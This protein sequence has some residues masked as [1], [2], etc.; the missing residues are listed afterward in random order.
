LP[1]TETDTTFHL[2]S[3]FLLE[4]FISEE[5]KMKQKLLIIT[6]LMLVLN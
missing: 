6:A 1:F 3:A 5:F 2:L 4:S